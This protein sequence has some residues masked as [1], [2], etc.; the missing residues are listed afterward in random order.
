MVERGWCL[1]RLSHRCGGRAA[2][3]LITTYFPPDIGAAM[4]IED[5][6]DILIFKNPRP[7]PREDI[8]IERLLVTARADLSR[9][10]SGPSLPRHQTG[11]PDLTT[12]LVLPDGDIA[13]APSRLRSRSTSSEHTLVLSYDITLDID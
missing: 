4:K 2:Y 5:F 12:E 1:R 9:K 3:L 10:N 13:T 6:H 7:L 11:K 8:R